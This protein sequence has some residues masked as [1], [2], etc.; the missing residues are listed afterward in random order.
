MPLLQRISFSFADNE[1]ASWTHNGKAVYLLNPYGDDAETSNW[2]NDVTE[3]ADLFARIRATRA[4]FTL[5]PGLK[6]GET[7]ER[8]RTRLRNISAMIMGDIPVDE[9]AFS[10][11]DKSGDQY[12]A[13]L[14][15]ERMKRLTR[16]GA[17]IALDRLD[18]CP[19]CQRMG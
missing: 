12:Q 18:E 9:D 13:V 11:D 17:K 3:I 1:V 4:G 7:T 19:T 8:V 2:C 16:K 14:D 10:E 6:P 15:D 5:P